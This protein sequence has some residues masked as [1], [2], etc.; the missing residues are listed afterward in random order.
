MQAMAQSPPSA[1]GIILGLGDILRFDGYEPITTRPGNFLDADGRDPKVRK[2]VLD[3]IRETIDLALQRFQTVEVRILPSNHDDRPAIVL[4]LA[5]SLF[6][7][8]NERV[9]FDDSPSRFWW[10]RI[11]KVFLGATHG[12]KTKMRDLPLVMAADNP[13]DWADSTYR[14]IYTGHIH[15]ESAV[16]ECGVVVTS[17]HSPV[18]K[19]AYHSFSKYRSGRSVYSDT[20]DVT[21]RMASSVKVNL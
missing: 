2:T 13:Q 17:M 10:R 7:E 11:G 3:M 9:I 6:Y 18:A 4:S 1:H 21:G 8:N 15:H 20:Y 5:F 16:E 14:R 12:D 19:D